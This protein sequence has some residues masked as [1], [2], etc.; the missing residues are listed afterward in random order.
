MNLKHGG[1]MSELFNKE[2]GAKVASVPEELPPLR[3]GYV[4]LIHQTHSGCAESLV[5]NGLIYNRE[6]AQKSGYSKYSD[7]TSMALAY[8]EDDFWDRLTKEEIRHKGADVIAIFDMPMEECGAH[9]R[10][11]IAQYLNGTI[12]RGY[13]VGIIPNYGTKGSKTGEKLSVSEMEEKKQIS[14]SNPL[15]PI[16]E[17][18]HWRE[19]VKEAENSY[20]RR[21]EEA[22]PFHEDNHQ[23]LIGDDN[24]DDVDWTS[25]DDWSDVKSKSPE[26]VFNERTGEFDYKN[27]EFQQKAEQRR[28]EKSANTDC[29]EDKLN[30]IRQK[31]GHENLEEDMGKTGDSRTGNVSEKHRRVAKIQLEAAQIKGQKS[32]EVR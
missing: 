13:I 5:E 25:L 18:P 21:M 6:Y 4:R 15:P 14:K 19:K 1:R 28:K 31:L 12:S 8:D 22:I 2:T 10:E 32:T 7:V 27:P 16:Y 24:F 29:L 20:R 9:Q 30:R 23:E 3:E 17:T 11:Q 26:Y